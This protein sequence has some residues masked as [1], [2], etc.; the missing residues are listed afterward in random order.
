VGYKTKVSKNKVIEKLQISNKYIISVAPSPK[1]VLWFCIICL[2]ALLAKLSLPCSLWRWILRYLAVWQPYLDSHDRVSILEV[3][4][5]TINKW[6][7]KTKG[8]TFNSFIFQPNIIFS[9][10][11]VIKLTHRQ[12]W[13][14]MARF[15][16]TSLLQ[17]VLC[18]L[19]SRYAVSESCTKEISLADLLRKPIVPI[20]VERTPWPPP[21]ANVI[22]IMTVIDSSMF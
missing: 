12:V 6:S 17:V 16:H 13:K 10:K 3:E 19:T 7:I 4:H 2:W 5:I 1:G 22:K 18:C 11:A 8:T 21:G 20:M 14:I 15:K 9:G